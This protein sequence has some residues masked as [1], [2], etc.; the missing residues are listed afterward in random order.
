MCVCGMCASL[1]GPL[2]NLFIQSMI[3]TYKSLN[4]SLAH[5][6]GLVMQVHQ[7]RGLLVLLMSLCDTCAPREPMLPKTRLRRFRASIAERR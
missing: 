4:S 1:C 7:G 2:L 5:V 3:H 6:G